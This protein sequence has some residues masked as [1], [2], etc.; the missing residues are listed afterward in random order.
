MDYPTSTL[1]LLVHMHVD[2]APPHLYI[3]H[4]TYRSDSAALPLALSVPSLRIDAATSAQIEGILG[5]HDAACT[6]LGCL[7]TLYGGLG[8][9]RVNDVCDAL[10]SLL[11]LPSRVY[12]KSDLSISCRHPNFIISSHETPPTVS[13]F[14]SFFQMSSIF[15]STKHS[16]PSCRPPGPTADL[17]PLARVHLTKNLA[18]VRVGADLLTLNVSG[19]YAINGPPL[20]RT[21]GALST[22]DG[23]RLLSAEPIEHVAHE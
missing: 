22:R 20:A 2:I 23:F 5:T 21:E 12:L 16:R 14:L 19:V 4:T 8:D 13:L 11:S 10:V 9:S 3:P 17:S 18:F 7:A 15:R 1:T 6:G